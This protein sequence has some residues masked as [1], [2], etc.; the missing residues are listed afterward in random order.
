MIRRR[1]ALSLL[2]AALLALALWRGGASGWPAPAGQPIAP[3]RA[4]GAAVLAGQL[5]V[6]GG[7]S[8][9]ATQ[10]DTVEV[11]EASSGRWRAGAAL[12]VARSQH[13]LVA[14]SGQLW[15]V[16]GW[17]QTR[18]LVP[19]MERWAPGAGW[20]VAAHLPQPRREPGAAAWDNE[21][22]IAG[23]FDGASDGDLEGYSTRVDVFD[24]ATRAWRRLPNL[25]V[26][27][28]G[29][30][31]VASG[32]Q[33]FALGGYSAEG[34]FLNVVERYTRGA[35]AWER[36]DWPITPR[37]WA[38]GVVLGDSVVLAGG[39]NLEGYQAR[40]ERVALA[41]GA[42]CLVRP[43]REPR[44]WLAAVPWEGGVLTLGGEAAGGMTGAVE[45]STGKCQ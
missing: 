31:L 1:W 35:S 24:P 13:A 34:G 7:W 5:F 40:I 33:L 27:R 18:G 19:E 23:G 16:A 38:A 11:W 41:T 12:Q 9:T 21:I 30:V 2:A 29:L 15:A 28:R 36:L 42:A 10:L 8:G 17:S 3:R 20:Q 14:V 26:P 22:V 4:L 44:A 43:L 39:Y 37:T 32:G 25:A 45:W 6:A